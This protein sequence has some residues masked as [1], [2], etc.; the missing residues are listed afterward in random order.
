MPPRPG[1]RRVLAEEGRIVNQCSAKSKRSG[2]RCRKP[3]TPGSPVCAMH[4][5]KSPRA[6]V[7]AERRLAEKL[8]ADLWGGRRDVHPAS[9][10]LELVG[11]KASEVEYW[12]H[13]VH[14]LQ[15]EDEAALTWGRT[16][17]KLGGE[18]H[19]TTREAKPHVA[20]TL[21]HKAEADL[22][23]YCAAALKAGV[24]ERMVQLAQTT[25]G[26]FRQI[27]TAVLADARLGVSADAVLIDQVVADALRAGV[28]GG[29]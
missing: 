12:R 10:L 3:A 17:E 23:A 27:I 26:Q 6:I 19:G 15:Q 7:A 25:A 18:D 29:R 2:E 13:R 16:K 4:G 21:L 28:E 20:L 14:E 22:A 24:E 11:W 8:A 5:S 9:A 1:S